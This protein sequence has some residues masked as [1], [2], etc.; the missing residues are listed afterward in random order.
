MR[1]LNL[2]QLK[3]GQPGI[4][5]SAGLFLSEAGA[6]CLM[7]NGH[8]RGVELYISGVEEEKLKVYWSQVLTEQMRK[9]WGDGEEATE[10]GAMGIAVLLVLKLTKYKILGRLVKGDRTDYLLG[11]ENDSNNPVA[12]MEVSGILKADSNNSINKRVGIKKRQVGKIKDR[13]YPVYI[14]VTEFGQPAAKF[15]IYE[16][17]N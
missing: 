13:A 12:K 7:K 8:Q 5:E 4:S 2:D 17:R 6:Y 15:L 3:K 14:A 1:R 10:Y 16:S 9:T 11:N